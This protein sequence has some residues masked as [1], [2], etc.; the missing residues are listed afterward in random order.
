MTWLLDN[1]VLSEWWKPNPDPKVVAFLQ[2][3][4]WAVPAP[5][6][7][8]IQEGAEADPS[9]ARR[10]QTNASL[11]E[12]LHDYGDVL[13]IN[14]DAETARTWGRLKHSQYVKRQPQPLWDSL[15]DAMAVRYG[16]I[17][18]TRNEKDFRHAKTFNPWQ[19]EPEK[20]KPSSS[21][22]PA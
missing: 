4:G 17:I 14:F 8:E 7:A 15:I 1:N 2:A 16:L 11:D 9:P 12:F 20:S 22:P 10:I 3:G 13:V 5:V 6:I 19:S 18:A 21:E